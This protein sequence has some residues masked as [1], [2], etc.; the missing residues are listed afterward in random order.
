[1]NLGVN[2]AKGIHEES[3]ARVLEHEVHGWNVVGILGQHTGPGKK[4][5]RSVDVT[6][7]KWKNVKGKF[8]LFKICPGTMLSCEKKGGNP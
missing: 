5:S 4:S 8:F 6:M 2:R 3:K 1:M 7:R